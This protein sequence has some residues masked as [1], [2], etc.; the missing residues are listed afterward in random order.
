MNVHM[1]IVRSRSACAARRT[2]SCTRSA[3]AVRRAASAGGWCSMQVSSPAE[4]WVQGL[5]G[6]ISR[7]GCCCD[8]GKWVLGRCCWPCCNGGPADHLLL[9]AQNHLCVHQHADVAAGRLQ[10]LPVR[11]GKDQVNEAAKGGKGGG[12]YFPL[13]AVQVRSS[14]SFPC[15]F[16]CAA[17]VSHFCMNPKSLVTC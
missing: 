6:C 15:E 9:P 7:T 10:T 4:F 8:V 3:V 2:T 17:H 14:Y 11:A 12:L 16:A 5:G 13:T 1:G